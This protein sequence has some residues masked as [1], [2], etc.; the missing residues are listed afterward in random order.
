M[1]ENKRFGSRIRTFDLFKLG[2]VLHHLHIHPERSRLV[3]T[4]RPA[5]PVRYCVRGGYFHSIEI[6]FISVPGK[7]TL[8]SDIWTA[9]ALH[10][11]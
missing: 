9:G 8:H 3:G 7:I 2:D 5:R 1:A 4:P 6:L 11:T 10:A